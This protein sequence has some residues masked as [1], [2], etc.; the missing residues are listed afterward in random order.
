MSATRPLPR[1]LDATDDELMRARAAAHAIAAATLGRD[2]G[3]MAVA[4][5]MSDYVYIGVEV[6]VKLVD[7]TGH[8]RLALEIAL[9]AHLPATQ[10]DSHRLQ[11]ALAGT[12]P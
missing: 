2:P 12:T 8:N 1:R 6:V 4:A 7:A 9:A 11:Q 10:G 5:S 3:L